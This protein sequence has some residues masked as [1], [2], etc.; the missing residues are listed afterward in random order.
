MV[1]SILFL[2]PGEKRGEL[3]RGINTRSLIIFGTAIIFIF[4]W[5][6]WGWQA[7]TNSSG[8]PAAAATQPVASN[9]TAKPAAGTAPTIIRRVQVVNVPVTVLDKRGFPVINLTEKDFE[10]YENGKRQRI[11]YFRQEPLPPL[12]IGLLLDTSNSMRP[13]MNFEKDAASD[14]VYRMLEQR[15]SVNKMFLMTFDSQSSLV[16]DFT[17]DP[18]AFQEK[19]RTLKAGGGKAIYDAIYNAC[20][21]KMLSAGQPEDTRRIL[22]LISDGIDVQSQHTMEE[23]VSMAHRAETAIYAIQNAAYGFDNPGDKYLARLAEETG[24]A[25]FYPLREGVGTDM[26]T[27]YLAHGNIGDTSQNKG[28][29]ADTGIFSAQK[30]IHLADALDSLGRDLDDQYSIGYTPTDAKLD[31]TYRAIHVVALRRGVAVRA[32]A[33]YF[34]LV[35]P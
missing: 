6:S 4:S 14:F 33:G 23:A 11:T 26:L 19:I 10:V 21:N 13:Q 31:G 15:G 24:G 18:D 3:G 9:S 8:P 35:Q 20:R 25:A 30:L 12:R 28:L 32:K 7:P 22:I 29:G 34:A 16:Q 17:S 5:R 2:E 1:K 27:G